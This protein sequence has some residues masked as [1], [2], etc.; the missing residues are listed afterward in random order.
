MAD[1]TSWSQLLVEIK[2]IFSGDAVNIDEVKK[3]MKSYESDYQDWKDYAKF[4]AHK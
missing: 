3:L 2:R 1:S 4:D